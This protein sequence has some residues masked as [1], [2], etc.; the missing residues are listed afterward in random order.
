ML[1]CCAWFFAAGQEGSVAGDGF[2]P[3][4]VPATPAI[5]P[6]LSVVHAIGRGPVVT[7]LATELPGPERRPVRTGKLD[8]KESK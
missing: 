7:P 8:P 4:W 1:D 6:R 5:P 2:E 3:S